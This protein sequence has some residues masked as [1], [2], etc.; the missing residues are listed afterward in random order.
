MLT[1]T[2]MMDQP[3]YDHALMNWDED[4]PIPAQIH[5]FVNLQQHEIMLIH[6]VS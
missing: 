1:Q 4:V 6:G 5:T 2:T 3:W